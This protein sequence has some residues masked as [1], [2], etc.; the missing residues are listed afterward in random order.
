MSTIKSSAENL[1]LNADGANND[2]KFQSNGS[3][4]AS[5]DQA[6][7]ITATT[8][9]G[10]GSTPSIT[11]NGNANAMTIDSAENVGIGVVPEAWHNDYRNLAVGGTGVLWSQKA[12]GTGKAMGVGQNVYY[13]GSNKYITTDEVS[14]YYQANGVHTFEVAA[15]GSADAAITFT[16]GLEVLN[17]GKTRAKNGLLF[18]TDTAAANALD[19]YE[20]GTF[21]PTFGNVSTTTYDLRWGIYTKIGNTVFFQ[22]AIGASNWDN[23]DSSSINISGLPFAIQTS[24]HAPFTTIAEKG[25]NVADV[26]NIGYDQQVYMLPHS[27]SASTGNNL[28]QIQYSTCGSNM[29][30]RVEGHYQV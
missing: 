21:T 2:I 4:V 26:V 6:G 9:T 24:H 7:T 25:V 3:E 29:R 27:F 14:R 12:V 23:S 1:T 15:S 17:D 18:G 16:T 11:D 10:A 22:L 19:D 20:E 8:F 28:S 5:I 30:F 13:D